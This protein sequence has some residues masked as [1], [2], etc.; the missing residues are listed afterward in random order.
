[1]E[2]K[3]KKHRNKGMIKS[4]KGLNYATFMKLFNVNKNTI[5]PANPDDLVAVNMYGHEFLACK[6]VKNNGNGKKGNANS[7]YKELKPKVQREDKPSE[8]PIW[9][10]KPRHPWFYLTKKESK[11]IQARHTKHIQTKEEYL[12]SMT[13]CKMFKWYRKNKQPKQIIDGVKNMFYDQELSNWKDQEQ[14][15]RQRAK[16]FIV[17]VYD[18]KPLY[19]RFMIGPDKYSEGYPIKM[20]TSS[21]ASVQQDTNKLRKKHM[22]LVATKIGEGDSERIILPKDKDGV[23]LAKAA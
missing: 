21:A 23:V 14:Q 11:Q 15:A 1:M 2:N 3:V 22:S 9:A 6:H 20:G 5:P 12:E 8:W 10:H 18:K 13:D 7:W 4:Q 16:D 19:G 17:S